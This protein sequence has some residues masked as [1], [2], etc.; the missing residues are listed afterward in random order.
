MGQLYIPPC[1]NGLNY[2]TI[3]SNLRWI[4]P[5]GSKRNA[6]FFVTTSSIVFCNGSTRKFL[7][8]FM[9]ATLI[10]Y[11]ANLDPANNHTNYYREIN[12][13]SGRT[14]IRPME[15]RNFEKSVS[16][17]ISRRKNQTLEKLRGEKCNRWKNRAL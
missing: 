7:I 3:D 8:T 15:N 14:K 17:K 10:W 5:S 13:F 6:V 9:R 16:G 1:L 11:M 12:V 4:P 2:S